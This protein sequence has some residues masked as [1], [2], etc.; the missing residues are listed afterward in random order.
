MDIPPGPRPKPKLDR[1][2][3]WG[4][5]YIFTYYTFSFI[6]NTIAK[7]SL[8]SAQII[9][10]ILLSSTRRWTKTL[11]KLGNKYLTCRPLFASFKIKLYLH[12]NVYVCQ[13]FKKKSPQIVNFYILV[14]QIGERLVHFWQEVCNFLYRHVKACQFFLSEQP[15][16]QSNI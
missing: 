4:V 16:N 10:V 5:F 6:P 15:C 11:G 8:V 12:K 3:K 2:P 1:P 7:V 13:P 9:Y 14:R